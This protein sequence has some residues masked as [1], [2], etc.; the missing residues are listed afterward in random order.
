MSGKEQLLKLG[1]ELLKR[2]KKMKGFDWKVCV[3]SSTFL[4]FLDYNCCVDTM[5]NNDHYN[6]MRTH[7]TMR[8]SY[9]TTDRQRY[10]SNNIIKVIYIDSVISSES[11][12][13]LEMTQ[14]TTPVRRPYPDLNT[15][16]E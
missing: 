13:K 2:L 10:T 7:D 8:K 9:Q 1:K 6:T 11:M 4:L 5:T 12:V 14:L 3:R 15:Q 16:W